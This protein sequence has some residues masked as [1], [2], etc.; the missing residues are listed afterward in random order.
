[1]NELIVKK[2]DQYMIDPQ[3]VGTIAE[4]EIAKTV[5]EERLKVITDEYDKLKKM[6]K[7]E[8]V[9]KR[10]TKL[11]AEDNN[12]TITVQCITPVDS[13]SFDKTGFK[14]DYP[15]LYN[16]YVSMKKNTPRMTIEVK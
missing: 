6:L 8:M 1:M 7:A 3:M 14:R 5:A 2:D 4:Y 15:S 13:E 12:R 9:Q 11:S 16:K 10:I